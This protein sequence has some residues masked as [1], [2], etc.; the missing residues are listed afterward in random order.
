MKK[1]LLLL[2]FVCLANMLFSSS[3]FAQPTVST[4]VYYCQGSTATALTATPT[5][6]SATLRWYSALTGG[7]EFISAP[8]P[9]TT[10]VA[11]TSYYV[12]QTIGGLESTPRTR[13]EVRVLADNGSSILSLRCDRTQIDVIV[14]KLLLLLQYIMQFTLIGQILLVYLINIHIAILLME[15][16]RFQE[17][18]VLLVCR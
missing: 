5:D 3:V 10:T 12:T 18:Q 2:V 11:N 14:L 15:V 7:T 13:I 17:L 4:P 8:I 6:P 16:L 1:N 9:S